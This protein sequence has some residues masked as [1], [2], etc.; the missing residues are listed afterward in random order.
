MQDTRIHLDLEEMVKRSNGVFGKSG[1]G[2]SFLTR[3]LLAGI[4]QKQAAVNLVFD[5]HSEYGWQGSSE[6]NTAVKGLKQLF[7]SK[8]AV[9]SLD[10]ESSRR[11]GISP[12]VEVKIGYKDIEPEDIEMLAEF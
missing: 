5:M 9:F 1:T 4:L 6:R 3:I 8:V 12:D 10:S 11:R 2:K 7:P